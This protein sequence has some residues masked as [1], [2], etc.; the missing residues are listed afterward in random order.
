[1]RIVQISPTFFRGQSNL[2]GGERYPLELARYLSRTHDAYLLSFG[3][4]RAHEQIQGVPLEIYPAHLLNNN[5]LNPFSLR[6]LKS[7]LNSDVVHVH[8]ISTMV[9]D[10]S[11][12]SRLLRRKPIFL[13][14][15]GGGGDVILNKRLPWLHDRATAILQSEFTRSFVSANLRNRA[16]VIKG[17]VDIERFF[18]D[19]LVVKDGSIL[20]IGRILPHKG[21]NYLIEAFR[22]LNRD[23]LKL[24]IVG[25]IYHQRFADDLKSQSANLNIEF[26]HGATDEEIIAYYRRA[27]LTVLPSVHTDLYGG[28]TATPELMGFTLTESQACGTPVICTDAGAMAEFVQPTRTGLVVKQSCPDSLAE[29]MRSLLSLST[30]SRQSMARNCR[31]WAESLSWDCVSKRHLELYQRV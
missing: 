15:H 8:Q 25:H 14:D 24:R 20:Y 5:I 13:T 19:P 11:C 28:Y 18:P 30:S 10:L 4:Q 31:S 1:M 23:G 27:E 3:K 2:G 22:K 17:G 12:L 21:V 26:I 9:A 16:V 6:F 7:T 29:A